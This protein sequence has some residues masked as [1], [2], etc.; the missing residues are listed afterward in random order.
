MHPKV[1]YGC[2]CISWAAYDTNIVAFHIFT[3]IV[4]VSPKIS[5][6]GEIRREY[7]LHVLK[8]EEEARKKREEE[9]RAS[10]ELIRKIQVGSLLC[11]KTSKNLMWVLLWALIWQLVIIVLTYSSLQTF[12]QKHLGILL[13]VTWNS[14]Q[15]IKNCDLIGSVWNIIYK[16]HAL[17]TTD[18]S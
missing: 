2:H 8:L 12:I 3:G 15:V 18:V 13:L 9:R 1:V 11:S 10:E 5:C 6:P 17:Q 4:R 14:I 16:H 7:E